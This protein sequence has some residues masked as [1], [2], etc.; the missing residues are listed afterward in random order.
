MRAVGIDIGSQQVKLI[1]VQTTSKGFQLVSAETRN[2]SRATGTDLELEVIEFLREACAKYDPATTRFCVALR[3]DRVAVRNKTFP[4]NDRSRIQK[5]L[6]FELEEDIPFSAENAVF[7]GKIVRFLGTT[8]EV[9]ACAAPKQHVAHLLQLMKDSNID[10]FIVGAEGVAFAN[11]FERWL[12]PIPQFPAPPPVLD[13]SAVEKPIRQLRIVLNIGHTHTTVLA[14]DGDT[15]IGVR[16][17]LWGGRNLID[18]IAQKYSL[19]PADAQKEMELKAFILTTRQDASYEAKIFSDLVA[20]SVRELVRDVQMSLLE[21]KAEFNG[22]ITDVRMTGGVSG[23]QG[24]GPFLTQH[25]EVPVNRMPVLDLFPNIAFERTDAGQLRYGVA[26]GLALEGL[27]KPRNP[28]VNFLK[29][30][31]ARQSSFALDLW[32]DWGAFIRAGAI[33][34]VL[35]CIW[36][37]GRGYVATALEDVSGELMRNQAKAVAR[38]SA[39]NANEAGV[40][41]FIRDNRK[42]ISE[43]RTLESLAKMN[44][45]MDVLMKISSS[46]PDGKFVKVDVNELDINDAAV[47]LAGSVR[48]GKDLVETVRKSLANAA[49]DGQV[50]LDSVEPGAG[51]TGFRMSFKVDRNIEKVTK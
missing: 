48:G 27:R 50:S 13:E 41:K 6:P 42:K 33:A 29:G 31:F 20:K 9:L 34:T 8:S 36:S 11:L 30:E 18:A 28:A 39:K 26:I 46:M 51:K 47:K 1:E 22:V 43:M 3:Q 12:D 2:L 35:L 38:L 21:F 14:L 32:K 15:L 40:K 49:A 19:A 25:L 44:S 37:W 23:I 45:A 24:L 16:S 4:F 10:P 17:V 5:T 7:D